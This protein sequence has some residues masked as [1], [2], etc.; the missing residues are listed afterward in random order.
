LRTMGLRLDAQT[1]T[2]LK[3]AQWLKSQPQV[4]RVLCP[5]L[6]SDPGHALWQRD[7]TGGCG[8][9]AFVLTSDDPQASARVADALELFGIGYSWGGYESLAL[10]IRPEDHRSTMPGVGG[11]AIR[12]AI[13]LEDADDLI[14]DLAQ[15]LETVG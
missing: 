2:A 7:F 11:P 15:A 9:F 1:R 3:I 14:A 10:P 12:L 8:L 6:P 5:L 13:G 4:A